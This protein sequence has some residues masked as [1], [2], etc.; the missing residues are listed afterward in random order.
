MLRLTRRMDRRKFLKGAAKACAAIAVPTII[1]ASA[2]GLG[3]RAA[4]SERIVLGGIGI[5]GRG[6]SVL[7][8]MLPEPDVQFVAVAD[9]QKT[10]RDA[11]KAMA[12]ARYENTDC[13]T[14]R[15][16]RELLAR[17]DIDA[18]LIASGDRWHTLHAIHAAA[19]GKDIYCEKPISITI[20]ETR[21]MEAA[22][23][24][25]GIIFQGGM[26]R[27]NVG[28]FVFAA[29]LARSG[30]LGR[31]H[32]VHAHMMNP[33]TTQDW[34]PEQ[35]EPPKEEL[36]WDLWLGPCPWRPYNA[37][38]LRGCGAWIPHFDLS[39]GGILGWG[40]HTIDLCQ[41]AADLEHTH[42][43]EYEPTEDGGIARYAN[44]IKLVMRIEGWMGLG[45][46]S[47][48][49]EGDAGWVEAGDTGQVR[50]H[51]ASLLAER[52]IQTVE[53]TNPGGHAREFFDCVKTRRL[54]SAN[55]HVAANSHITS[56][57]AQIAY[58]LNSPLKWDPAKYEFTNS[59]AANRLR[60]R[61]MREPWKI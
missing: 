8:G 37:G 42:A 43:V 45:T 9:V 16:F 27:R 5:G 32:T 4:P 53:G 48:R 41:W 24:R 59:D 31:L 54:P 40:S 57:A 19:A 36:D 30:K 55:H 12:D 56:H 51:P 10:R 2:L 21:A 23:D 11:A 29:S 46:C 7:Q 44:G 33:A 39:A 18:V 6:G 60:S 15:D 49:Y 1:P 50:C 14:Y 61:A 26:Q 20:A 52:K 34:L 25:A 38:Y 35:P 17:P 28:N 13:A 22:I 47:A 3:D 58:W